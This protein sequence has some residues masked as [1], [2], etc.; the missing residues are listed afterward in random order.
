MPIAINGSG[1]VTGISVGGLPD[2]IVDTDMIAAAAVTAPKRGAGA[3]LQVVSHNLSSTFTTTATSKTDV[4]GMSKAITPSAASSKI[5]VTFSFDYDIEENSDSNVLGFV[6]INR[7]VASGSVYDKEN[8]GYLFNTIPVFVRE[9]INN[10][11]YVDFIKMISQ[12]FDKIN[13]YIK[14]MADI[15]DRRESISE[16]LSK[17]L[18]YAVAKSVGLH[19]F[20]GKDLVDLPNYVLGQ[21]VSSSYDA[22][23]RETIGYKEIENTE[24][25]ISREIWSRLLANMPLFLQSKGTQKAMKGIINSYGI[26]SSILRVREYGGPDLDGGT[27]V[28]FDI[29]RKFTKSLISGSIAQ[30]FNTVFPTAKHAAM[31]KFSVAPTL[32]FGNFIKFPFNLPFDFAKIYPFFISYF[33]PSFFNAFKWKFIGLPDF[34]FRTQPPGNEVI[35]LWYFAIIGPKTSTPALIVFTE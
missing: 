14:H 22:A 30:F 23:G 3:I 7:Q 20:D 15:N 24:Q 25:D 35:D 34:P 27:P 1:T 32:I 11:S 29:Q 10:K 5:K 28:N 12:Y 33:I 26:P 17:E 19:V 6:Y 31:I 21:Q 8:P 18:Y 9:D 13:G 4:T 2:G 16:G